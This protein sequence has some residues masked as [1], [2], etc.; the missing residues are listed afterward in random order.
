MD[1]KPP[2][3]PFIEEASPFSNSI[4]DSQDQF[5]S[6]NQTTKTVSPTFQPLNMK[7]KSPYT[8]TSRHT[9]LTL[10]VVYSLITLLTAASAFA[11]PSLNNDQ[12]GIVKRSDHE[13][14]MDLFSRSLAEPELL[15]RQSAACWICLASCGF[16]GATADCGCC[17]KGRGCDDDCPE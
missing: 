4:S 1:I 9:Q 7:R 15:K 3:I 2:C 13:R 17:A 16:G 11:A 10:P 5:H 8:L 12:P 14:A 6:P